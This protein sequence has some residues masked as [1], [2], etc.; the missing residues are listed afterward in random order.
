MSTIHKLDTLPLDAVSGGRVI[1]LT[2]IP[3]SA[4]FQAVDA[5][6]VKHGFPPRH[7]YWPEETKGMCYVALEDATVAERAV[8]IFDDFSFCGTQLKARI[9]DRMVTPESNPQPTTSSASVSI[10]KG[11][12]RDSRNVDQVVPG[13]V[14]LFLDL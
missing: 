4:N 13:L 9:V 2:N 7:T 14:V 10:S 11:L 1:R 6:L 8:E 3:F 12:E 5:L